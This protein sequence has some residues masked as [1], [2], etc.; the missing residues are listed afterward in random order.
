MQTVLLL[1]A[2]NLEKVGCGVLIFVMCYIANMLLGVWENVKVQGYEFDKTLILN[3]I[4]K[5][6][7]FGVAITLLSVSISVIPVY[8]GYIG[9]AI[10]EATL[11]AIDSTIIIGS[12]LTASFNY[13]KDA[14]GK[15]KALLNV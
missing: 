4:I 7:V 15:L 14:L 8:V 9:I 13:A 1:I 5:F 6:F 12:F 10:E 2:T 11:Q 3:S